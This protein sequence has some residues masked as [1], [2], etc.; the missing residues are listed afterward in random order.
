MARLAGQKLAAMDLAGS[1]AAVKK[2]V[3]G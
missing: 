2:R 3:L 1:P